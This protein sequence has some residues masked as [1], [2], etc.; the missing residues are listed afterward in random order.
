MDIYDLEKDKRAKSWY[1][2]AG[3]GEKSW[4]NY[5]GEKV[6]TEQSTLTG[7]ILLKHFDKNDKSIYDNSA[8]DFRTDN[9][10][11]ILRYADIVLMYV[12]SNV[13]QADA[14][15]TTDPAVQSFNSIRERAG[16]DPVSC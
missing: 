14:G 15:V 1:V 8:Y 9:N 7:Y 12:R 16:L 3:E 2:Y 5:F 10:A 6:E 13:E 4:I 11:I